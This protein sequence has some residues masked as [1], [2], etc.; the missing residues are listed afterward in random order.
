MQKSIEESSKTRLSAL[1]GNAWLSVRSIGG[2]LIS[3]IFLLVTA[4]QLGAL[5]AAGASLQLTVRPTP[6]RFGSVLLGATATKTVTVI[7]AGSSRI[8]I[9]Q[10]NV[11]GAEFRASGIALPQTLAP[12]QKAYFTASFAPAATGAASGEL[13]VLSNAPTASSSL[14]GTGITRSLAANPSGLN[15]GAVTQGQSSSQTVTLIATG[16]SSVKISAISSSGTGFSVSGIALPLTLAAGGSASFSATFSPTSSGTD[17]GSIS[18]V[19]NASDATLSISLSGSS[20]AA[21][22]AVSPGS[23]SF[24]TVPVGS[25]S[26]QT[27]S[28]TNTGSASATITQVTASGTGFAV[29]GIALP[30]TL[31]AGQSAHFSAT[32]SPSA[33]GSDSGAISVASNAPNSPFTVS[34]S[35]AGSTQTVSLSPGSLSFGNVTTGNSSVLPVVLTNTGSASV[36]ISQANITGAGFTVSGPSLPLSLASGQNTSFS[37]TFAPMSAGSATGTVSIVSNA[38][39]SPSASSLSAMGVNQHSVTLGWT[40]SS[41]PGITGYNVYSGTSSG[42]PYTQLNSALVTNTTYTDTTVQA[43]QTYYFVTTAVDSQGVE[44]AYSNQAVAIVPSP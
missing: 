21:Q 4:T 38:A 14:T 18:V 31:A 8:T 34:L 28:L 2:S 20:G 25:Q 39:N 40:A 10:V 37:V 27:L 33:A 13:S 36:T 42:G 43:G 29:S 30:L 1:S 17:S 12:R 19:S 16:T 15:F 6:V 32:F 22:V 7:N 3:L 44:S 35:G 41:S 26:T 9:T 11:T 23:L 24:G 5:G